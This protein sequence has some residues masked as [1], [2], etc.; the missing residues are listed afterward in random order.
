MTLFILIAVRD[1]DL[2]TTASKLAYNVTAKKAGRTKHSGHAAV[3]RV[4]AS[5]KQGEKR[6]GP[7]RR[8]HGS[9]AGYPS[10]A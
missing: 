3:D 5:A 10:G 6:T 7:Y 1:H 8:D 4:A 9:L 2:R